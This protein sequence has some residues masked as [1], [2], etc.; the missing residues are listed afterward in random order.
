[1]RAR[2]MA[3]L[4]VG[5]L[6]TMGST[7]TGQTP[8]LALRILVLNHAGAPPSVVA[9]AE[10]RAGR[11]FKA[12]GVNLTCVDRATLGND[13]RPVDYTVMILSRE[14]TAALAR[15]SAL[16]PDNVMGFAPVNDS[17]D[18]GHIAYAFYHRIDDLASRAAVPVANVLGQVMAHELGHLLL[19]LHGHSDEGI[20]R[21]GWTLTRA[22]TG[23]FTP[24]QAEQIR[25]YLMR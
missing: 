17:A 7:V 12:A 18:H 11:V 13:P 1:M 2:T 4:G 16:G 24:R 19:G 21:S 6:M 10:Q 23:R 15:D 20:M 5:A 9:A 22:L 8:A 3:A 14:Q 25:Q